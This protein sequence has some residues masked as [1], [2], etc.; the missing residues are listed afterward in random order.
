MSVGPTEQETLDLVAEWNELQAKRAELKLDYDWMTENAE[1]G[2][3]DTVEV[4][5][6]HPGRRT[7]KIRSQ[8]ILADIQLSAQIIDKRLPILEQMLFEAG[9]VIDCVKP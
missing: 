8:A 2:N 3:S 5:C 4:M 6:I 7:L 9:A 1:F